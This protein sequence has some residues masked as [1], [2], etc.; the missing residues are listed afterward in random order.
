MTWEAQVS[1][2][3]KYVYMLCWYWVFKQYHFS[4]NNVILSHLQRASAPS[5]RGN[6][7]QYLIPHSNPP[8][9]TFLLCQNCER[10]VH[11]IDS[12]RLPCA[13]L[14]QL[15]A[16]H[17]IIDIFICWCIWNDLRTYENQVSVVLIKKSQWNDTDRGKLGGK[18]R[19]A[20]I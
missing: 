1:G 4:E 15:K 16:V 5:V 20:C 2:Q 14:C 17:I 18:R 8:S 3:C 10:M 7:H 19:Q 9:S 6:C 13:P 11:S 12:E